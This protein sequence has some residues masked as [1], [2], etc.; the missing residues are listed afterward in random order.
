MQIKTN[1]EN[2]NAYKKYLLVEDATNEFLKKNGYL[3]LDLPVLSP[4]LIPESY[5]EVFE[6]DF[7]H[8]GQNRK[9]YLTPSPELFLKRALA[10]GVGDCYYLG[11][12][13]RNSDPAATLHSFEFT[14]LEFY[15]MGAD[16]MD[17]AS[18]V[19]ALLQ[20]INTKVKNRKIN[21][22]KWEKLTVAEAFEKYAQIKE[23]EL[24]DHNL[25]EKKASEK[26]YKT[27]G[28]TYEDI[29]SQIYTQEVEPFM[30]KNGYPTLIYDYPKEFAA[31][32]KHNVGGK[33]SQRFEFYINGVEL[34]DCYTELTDWKEQEMR[35]AD[36][37]KRRRDSF[38][39]IHPIDKGF[40]EALK[41]GLGNCSGIAIGMDRLAMVF[42]DVD[43]IAKLKL[44]NIC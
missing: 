43:T 42:A 13:F 3:K 26:G 8:N 39:T 9:L 5:L 17:I 7:K 30:G 35:F 19:L 21:L 29:W 20:F 40:I 18:E 10:Y 14:M 34:G 4:S 44:I 32:A 24:F 31:L 36:E 12:S 33:T 1:L 22:D 15:K 41:Y 25:F 6:T 11:K 2:L 38:K 37:E 16:Y 27:K 28:F 23:K